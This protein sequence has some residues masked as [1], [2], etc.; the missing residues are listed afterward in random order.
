MS[1]R[2]ADGKQ[3]RAPAAKRGAGKQYRCRSGIFIRAFRATT[4]GTP[5][6]VR[7]LLSARERQRF[8]PGGMAS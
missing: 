4:N 5:L 2:A 1:S 3:N 7:R 6:H 8:S